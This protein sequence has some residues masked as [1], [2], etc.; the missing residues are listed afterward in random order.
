MVSSQTKTHLFRRI[1]REYDE[2]LKKQR[3]IDFD[4][5]L[6][7]CVKLLEQNKEVREK[8]YNRFVHI[9]VGELYHGTASGKSRK[10]EES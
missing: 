8:Y 6:M 4:D 7:L 1:Y 5:M 10:P 9:L 3:L 2:F